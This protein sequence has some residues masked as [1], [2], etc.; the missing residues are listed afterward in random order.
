MEPGD[1][2]AFFDACAQILGDPAMRARWRRRAQ[3]AADFDAPKMVRRYEQVFEAAIERPR[4]LDAGR[5]EP[6][7]VAGLRMVCQVRRRAL[8]GAGDVDCDIVL[9]TRDHDREFGGA[10][11]AMRA[12]VAATLGQEAAHRQLGGRVRSPA[13]LAD[14][15]RLRRARDRWDADVVHVQDSLANDVRLAF[16][17]GLRSGRYALTV[18]DP[19]P[20]PGDATPP[21]GVSLLRRSLRRRAGLVFVHSQAWPRN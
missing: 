2:E 8:P 18:H 19:V 3:A 14:M 9:L 7:G 12:F 10:E 17:S 4:C 5:P 21:Q 13:A 15:V 11:G 1:E 16:A 6:E 20:H